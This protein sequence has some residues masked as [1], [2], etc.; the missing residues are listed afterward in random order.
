AS[1]CGYAR[2]G[3]GCDFSGSE[4][5]RTRGT[6]SIQAER[7]A[8][9]CDQ[10]GCFEG[11]AYEARAESQP[12]AEKASCDGSCKTQ[13]AGDECS[14]EFEMEA[15]STEETQPRNIER[16]QSLDAQGARKFSDRD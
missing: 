5:G 14:A 3:E 16:T 1:A 9:G 12:L 15:G 8:R 13:A 4:T 10:A 2:R 6:C 11:R 7:A